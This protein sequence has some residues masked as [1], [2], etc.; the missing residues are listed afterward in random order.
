MAYI[1]QYITEVKRM[2]KTT[3]NKKKNF[4]TDKDPSNIWILAW[5]NVIKNGTE[6]Q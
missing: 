6:V 2:Y 5:Y 1:I 4:Y 3:A